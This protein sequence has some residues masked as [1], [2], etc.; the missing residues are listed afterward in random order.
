MSHLA[1]LVYGQMD[2]KTSQWLVPGTR[3]LSLFPGTTH[4]QKYR[5]NR[6]TATV[7]TIATEATSRKASRSKSEAR[8]GG[9]TI[10]GGTRNSCPYTVERWCQS[11]TLCRRSSVNQ[12]L[13]KVSS[14]RIRSELEQRYG[15]PHEM[16]F[17]T[18]EVPRVEGEHRKFYK[19]SCFSQ[20]VNRHDSG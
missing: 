18:S 13:A 9:A 20:G 4:G 3:L 17:I 7:G 1:S 11:L 5:L 8:F 16:E 15:K 6:N 12:V 19:H 2:R 14:R 10:D